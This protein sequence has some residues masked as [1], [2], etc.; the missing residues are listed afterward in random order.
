[1]VPPRAAAVNA[2]AATT[3]HAAPFIPLPLALCLR[4]PVWGGA[5]RCGPTNAALGQRVLRRRRIPW[6]RSARLAG[7]CLLSVC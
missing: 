5:S 3:P 7:S 6:A 1:M 4:P 2:H